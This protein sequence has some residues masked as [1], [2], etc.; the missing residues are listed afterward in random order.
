MITIR[1]VRSS[2]VAELH[3]GQ[4]APSFRLR[5]QHGDEVSSDSLHGARTVLYF[6]PK[7]DTPG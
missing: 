3:T 7:A 5:D 2:A 6:F 4:Q 1:S